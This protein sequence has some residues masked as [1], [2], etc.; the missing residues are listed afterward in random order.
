MAWRIPRVPIRS[1]EACPHAS[2]IGVDKNNLPFRPEKLP[3]SAEDLNRVGEMF[4]RVRQRHQVVAALGQVERQQVARMDD[5]SS[6]PGRSGDGTFIEVH[7]LNLPP[8]SR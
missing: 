2:G 8:R 3:N 4:E 6:R 5:A 1:E 7:A